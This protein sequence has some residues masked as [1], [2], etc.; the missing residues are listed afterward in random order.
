MIDRTGQALT[1]WLDLAQA[2][3]ASSLASRLGLN[4]RFELLK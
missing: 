1:T 2:Y 3:E 4:A